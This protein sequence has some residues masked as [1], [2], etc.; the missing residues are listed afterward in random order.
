MSDILDT[1]HRLK[2]KEKTPNISENGSL[3]SGEE[4]A[5]LYCY[6]F[7]VKGKV[8]P[9]QALCGPEGG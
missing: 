1:V 3:S 7:I 2:Q 5:G 6:T 9:L 4:K 8:I